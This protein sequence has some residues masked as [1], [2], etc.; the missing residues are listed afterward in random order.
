VTSLEENLLK[1]LNNVT[2]QDNNI[3]ISK[4]IDPKNNTIQQNFE[5]Q[6]LQDKN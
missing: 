6:K 5:I 2:D 3:T 4:E 1:N